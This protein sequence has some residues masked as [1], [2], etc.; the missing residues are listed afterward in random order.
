MHFYQS[1]ISQLKA[2]I[3]KIDDETCHE[4]QTLEDL[5]ESMKKR[6]EEAFYV[7]RYT[8]EDDIRIKVKENPSDVQPRSP[9]PVGINERI[10]TFV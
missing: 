8:R 4:K 5:I 6:D 7:L 2:E 10:G 1:E 3:L 9:F